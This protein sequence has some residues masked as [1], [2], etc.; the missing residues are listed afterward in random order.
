VPD[1]PGAVL[2]RSRP[3]PEGKLA[4]ASLAGSE[5]S[6]AAP[7]LSSGT[8]GNVLWACVL[9]NLGLCF[10]NS[11]VVG[12]SALHVIAAV[13]VILA[14]A[15]LLPFSRGA[16]APGRM[17]LLLILLFGTWLLLSILRQNADPKYFRDVAIIPLFILLGMASCNGEGLH[18]RLFWLHIV[19]LGF[20]LWE[21]FAVTSFVRV[22]SIADYFASTRGSNTLAWSVDSGLFLS[23]VRPEERFLFADLPIHRLSSVFLEP[24]S[25][26]NYVVIATI[27]LAGFWK[28]I[29]AWMRFPAVLATLLLLAGSDSRM[30]TVTCL[31]ILLA[32]PFKR[33]IFP[34]APA[35]T[36]PLVI[37]AMALVAWALDLKSG[38]DDF[39]G[40]I[41]HAVEV[42]GAFRLEDYAGLSLAQ[43]EGSED[44]GFA[45]I[46]LTQSLVVAAIL[47]A[48][49]FVRKLQSADSRYVH[50]AIAL[51]VALNL[52]V[53]WSLFSIKTAA[54]VWV[55]LGRSIRDDREGAAVDAPAPLAAAAA[56]PAPARPRR[57]VPQRL[58]ALSNSA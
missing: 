52:T 6:V 53:S 25:L 58:G 40:R 21:A 50:L 51:Y 20:A 44:A 13:A 3:G 47:W 10:V 22:F 24:V 32:L 14:A 37:A 16:R 2:T 43:L 33:F 29:P 7:S 15:F 55:L 31:A 39:G 28:Q 8:A 38:L 9:F 45:Y 5:S 30:A 17:D 18:R 57:A 54:I 49:L 1:V 23:S 42:L 27:W 41:A 48:C 19:I 34:L 26:G 46:I 11:S 36:A 4:G 56:P 12:I 35:L